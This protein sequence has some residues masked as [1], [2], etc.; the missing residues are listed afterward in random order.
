MSAQSSPAGGSSDIDAKD[1]AEKAVKGAGE[2][3]GT[4]PG[5]E[6]GAA[7]GA[8]GVEGPP[9]SA[10]GTPGVDAAAVVKGAA[11]KSTENCATGQAVSRGSRAAARG[12]VFE[13]AA[14]EVGGSLQSISAREHA[15][16]DATAGG[17]GE[18]GAAPQSS[19]KGS[20]RT[21]CPEFLDGGGN[22]GT[23]AGGGGSKGIAVEEPSLLEGEEGSSGAAAVAGLF[24]SLCWADGSTIFSL[25]ASSTWDSK[26]SICLLN[27]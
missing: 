8:D 1:V 2:M 27:S 7:E 26:A 13:D 25:G 21:G 10:H 9:Q 11:G 5:V 20:S 4:A 23:D 6:E 18:F 15:E 14:G 22:N 16:S 3:A 19:N 24:W 17:D 12:A